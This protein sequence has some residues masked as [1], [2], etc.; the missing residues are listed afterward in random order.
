MDFFP[1][2]SVNFNATSD[3]HH[4]LRVPQCGQP[5]GALGAKTAS[6][7]IGQVNITIKAMSG[8]ALIE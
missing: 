7:H 3:A 5:K 8:D 4:G 1:D 6:D 2:P